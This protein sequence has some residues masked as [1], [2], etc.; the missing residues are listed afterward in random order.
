[1]N[2]MDAR[3]HWSREQMLRAFNPK[4]EVWQRKITSRGRAVF[5]AARE[6][7]LS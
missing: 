7:L 2:E 3:R 6:D 5:N 1:M 4:D